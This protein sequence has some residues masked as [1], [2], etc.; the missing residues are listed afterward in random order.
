MKMSNV[1]LALSGVVFGGVLLSS[2][3]SAAEGRLVVYCSDTKYDVRARNH[4]F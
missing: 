3:A 4:G 2:H 1:A